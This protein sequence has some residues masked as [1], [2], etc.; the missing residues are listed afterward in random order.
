LENQHSWN[1]GLGS[2]V[3]AGCNWQ[4][5]GSAFVLGIEGEASYLKLQGSAFDPLRSPTA[6]GSHAGCPR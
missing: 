1:I 6:G 5:V 2:S 3:T 4:P